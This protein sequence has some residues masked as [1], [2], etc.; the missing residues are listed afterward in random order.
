M[1][2]IIL[3]IHRNYPQ[4]SNGFEHVKYQIFYLLLI[5]LAFLIFGLIGIWYEKKYH[6]SSNKKH[7]P[8]FKRWI[9]GNLK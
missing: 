1:K 8:Q 4:S 2:T 7:R 3:F 5:P 6:K 9:K